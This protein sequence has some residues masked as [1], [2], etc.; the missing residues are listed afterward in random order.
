M[1]NMDLLKEKM[2]EEDFC[3]AFFEN[4]ENI[5][6]VTALLERSGIEATE[7]EIL[8]LVKIAKEQVAKDDSD[9]LSEED[10]EDV[11]GGMIGFVI[12]LTIVIIGYKIY[13]IKTMQNHGGKKKK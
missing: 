5:S 6:E 12:I 1:M 13:K 11:S 8:E 10:L 2:Q 3:V 9:E 7:E 4:L